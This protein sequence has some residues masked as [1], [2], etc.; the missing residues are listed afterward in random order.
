MQPRWSIDHLVHEDDRRGMLSCHDEK[1]SNH[2]RALSDVLLHEFRSLAPKISNP[3]IKSRG[4]QTNSP[5]LLW[6]NN[7]CDVR[8]LEQVKFFR[9]QEARREEPPSVEI[10]R[11][12]RRSPDAWSAVRSLLWFPWPVSALR[13]IQYFEN[14]TKQPVSPI[15]PKFRTSSPELSLHASNWREDRLYSEESEKKNEWARLSNRT[16][17]YRPC[18]KH[19][20]RFG[21]R[22]ANSV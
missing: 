5:R 18:A 4:K 15:H 9:F 12:S 11:D 13:Y 19:S 14:E 17:S 1:L 2:S 20:C 22:P 8:L 21:E 10:Y 16:D 6:N 7:P 3:W